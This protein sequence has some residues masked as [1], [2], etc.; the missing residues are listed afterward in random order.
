MHKTPTQNTLAIKQYA[1]YLSFSLAYKTPTRALTHKTPTQDML[2]IKQGMH[3]LF[4]SLSHK[5]R[6]SALSHKTRTSALIHKTPTRDMYV[7]NQAMRARSLS[8]SHKT[9]AHSHTRHPR[10]NCSL[11]YTSME[12]YIKTI[13]LV[14]LLFIGGGFL[15]WN[16]TWLVVI[17]RLAHDLRQKKSRSEN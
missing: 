14:K 5:T 2:A 11:P 15:V 13:S 1:H 10:K 6:T 17:G 12:N 9:P 4:L 7:L 8:L 16:A 3:A